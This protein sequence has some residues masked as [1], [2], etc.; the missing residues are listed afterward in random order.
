MAA[1]LRAF[2]PRGWLARLGLRRP[3][4]GWLRAPGRPLGLPAWQQLEFTFDPAEVH[5]GAESIGSL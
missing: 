1:L 5:A 2:D 4:F 3:D